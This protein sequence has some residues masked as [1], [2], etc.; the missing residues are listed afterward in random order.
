MHDIWNPWHGC[1]KVSEGCA[2]CYM[3]AMDRA[4]ELDGSVVRRNKTTFDYPLQRRRDGSYRVRTG[5]LIR[6]CMTSDFL[7]E[8]ADPW[9]DEAWEIIHGRP[10]VRFFIL[11]KRPERFRSCLPPDWGD[12][13]PNVMLNVT[14][15]NQRRAD[16]HTASAT[17]PCRHNRPSRVVCA[18]S[19]GPSNGGSQTR[20]ACR[21]HARSGPFPASV[22]AVPPAAALPSATAAP[23]AAN[24]GGHPRS[25]TYLRN[26][27]E[28]RH[29]ARALCGEGWDYSGGAIP[30]GGP[31]EV[32]P[33]PGARWNRHAPPPPR[34]C[35]RWTHAA[36]PRG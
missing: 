4:H 29:D 11:T 16:E 6:I 32:S 35:G 21:F 13:W 10:D 26:S 27:S 30:R 31:A 2:H 1:T 12:G 8:Q 20:S 24:A 34:S 25:S 9:R 5:E 36:P 18:T 7:V 19:E 28:R 23:T 14:C 17:S 22:R 3:Y 33:S 15:E